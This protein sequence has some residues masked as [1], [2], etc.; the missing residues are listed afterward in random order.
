[1]NNMIIFPGYLN[2]EVIPYKGEEPR[3]S[4]VMELECY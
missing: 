4:L 1:M 3:M 2:H